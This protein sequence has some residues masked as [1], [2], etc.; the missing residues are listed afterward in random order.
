M[1]SL[2]NRGFARAVHA[3]DQEDTPA[4]ITHGER[5]SVANWK[6]L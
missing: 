4:I 1:G 2:H 6:D 5:I 3:A